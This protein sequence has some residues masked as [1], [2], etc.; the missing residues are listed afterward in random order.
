VHEDNPTLGTHFVLQKP[1]EIKYSDTAEVWKYTIKARKPDIPKPSVPFTPPATNPQTQDPAVDPV[2]FGPKYGTND[3]E[4]FG[5]DWASDFTNIAGTDGLDG[6]HP[7]SGNG[8]T[9]PDKPDET[10]FFLIRVWDSVGGDP[11]DEKAIN[12]R[13]H[14]ALVVGMNV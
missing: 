11:A 1:A 13:L 10:A 3:A 2:V 9:K 7:D 5:F 14:D 12:A 6:S 8:D 4:F